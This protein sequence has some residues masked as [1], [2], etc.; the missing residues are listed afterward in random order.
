[1]SRRPV[2]LLLDEMLTAIGKIERYVEGLDRAAFLADER[3]GDAVVRNL[4]VIGEAAAR[5]PEAF[6]ASASD[7]PWRRIVGLRN[8]IVHEYFGID[9]EIV[10]EIVRTDLPALR[11]Q[12]AELHSRQAE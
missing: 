1:M 11:P 10:W 4:E 7:I 8:R 12:L 2:T 3:T 5:L 9:L 6:R